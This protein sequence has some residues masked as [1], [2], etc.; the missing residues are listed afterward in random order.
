MIVTSC[1]KENIK[2]ETWLIPS[3]EVTDGGPGKDG[4]PALTNPEF[5]NATEATYLSDDDLI[6]GF[7]DGNESR[8]Y[9]HPILDQHE[10]VNDNI[11]EHSL[12]VI[13]CPL[14][15]TGIAW[16]R[17]I[18]NSETTFGVSGLLYNSNVIPYDR[19][20]DSNWS[21]MLL[22]CVN[23]SLI[24][25]EAINY[26]LIETSW[27]TWKQ[28][29]PNTKVLSDNTGYSRNYDVYPYGSYKFNDNLLFPVSNSDNRL[30]VKERVLGIL[31]EGKAKAYSIETFSDSV[32][33]FD[34]LFNTENLVIAGS[35]T[36]NFIV[37]FKKG[38]E[39]SNFQAVQDALPIIMIDNEGTSWDVT[40]KAI[41]GPRVGEQLETVTQ[42]M[43]YWFSWGA[44]YPDIVIYE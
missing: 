3:D 13:Y 16:S 31:I 29:Y 33:V 27:K 43:G 36:L 18:N 40:G 37:A 9:P 41:S 11:G 7:V 20:T 44:F 32:S 39:N 22:K 17:I 10:I 23:G 24:G 14:T 19:S 26:N 2:D 4:I 5:I 6:L 28:M 25:K 34:D 21:Q 15:G 42:F 8:A 1:K 38:I 12:A 35:K 30:P